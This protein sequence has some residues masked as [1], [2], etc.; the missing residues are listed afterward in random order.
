MAIGTG[1][2]FRTLVAIPRV[3]GPISAGV[4]LELV[5]FTRPD[6]GNFSRN[7]RLVLSDCLLERLMEVSCCA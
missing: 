1:R 3:G 2:I 5:A 7:G 6:R 4:D